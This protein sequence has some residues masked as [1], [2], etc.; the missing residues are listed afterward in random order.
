MRGVS[1]WEQ[2]ENE[3][4]RNRFRKK[5]MSQDLPAHH[6]AQSQEKIR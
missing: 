4:N 2:I 3:I 1:C 5:P 6:A